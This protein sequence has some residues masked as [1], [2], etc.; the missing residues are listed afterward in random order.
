MRVWHHCVL[1]TAWRSPRLRASVASGPNS[2]LSRWVSFFQ[3]RWPGHRDTVYKERS[4]R[5]HWCHTREIDV[6]P[7]KTNK[8]VPLVLRPKSRTFVP[9][10]QKGH[11]DVNL[12]LGIPLVDIIL[13]ITALLIG[14]GLFLPHLLGFRSPSLS[15]KRQRDVK[16][17]H[18]SYHLCETDAFG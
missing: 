15:R 12:I 11:W 14:I 10:G 16:L 8:Q 2:I 13:V 17:S 18:F 7:D 6:K 3:L 5:Y 9:K 4:R 1:F